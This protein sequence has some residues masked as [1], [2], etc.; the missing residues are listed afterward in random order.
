MSS[1]RRTTTY[2]I[3]LEQGGKSIQH[4]KSGCATW[5]VVREV[6]VDLVVVKTWPAKVP[7]LLKQLNAMLHITLTRYP[8]LGKFAGFAFMRN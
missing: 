3:D 2:P 5:Q 4:N 6:P 8:S 1:F 7:V